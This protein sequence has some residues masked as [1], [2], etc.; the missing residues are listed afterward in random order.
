VLFFVA[1]FF[2]TAFLAAFLAATFLTATFLVVF[3]AAFF[4]AFFFTAGVS[5][6]NTSCFCALLAGVF[7]GLAAFFLE[8]GALSTTS[9][10]WN[11]SCLGCLGLALEGSVAGVLDGL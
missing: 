4:A 3:L 9:R 1:V 10:G 11:E 7:F 6:T 5:D 2:T 8:F